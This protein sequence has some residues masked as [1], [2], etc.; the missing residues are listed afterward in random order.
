MMYHDSCLS[1]TGEV[2]IKGSLKNMCT[3]HKEGEM[4]IVFY[5]WIVVMAVQLCKSIKNQWVVHS[6]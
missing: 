6:E 1:E 5:N 4:A 2:N 3:S